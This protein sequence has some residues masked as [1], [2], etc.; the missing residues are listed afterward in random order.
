MRKAGGDKA[1][2][3]FL[4]ALRSTTDALKMTPAERAERR[5]PHSRTLTASNLGR[6]K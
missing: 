6:Q 2:D 1:A 5:S 3:G 4:A